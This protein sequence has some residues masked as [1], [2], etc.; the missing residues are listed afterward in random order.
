MHDRAPTRSWLAVAAL[1]TIVTLVAAPVL[2]AQS[3]A[4]VLTPPRPPDTTARAPQVTRPTAPASTANPAAVPPK[5][6][7]VPQSALLDSIREAVFHSLL[8]HDRAGFS[9]LASA[10]CLGL[11]T[12]TFK[13]ASNLADRAD[14]PEAMVRRLYTPRAPARRA[15]TCTFAP[16]AAARPVPGRALLYSVGVIDMVSPEHAEAAAAYSYDGYSA[17]GYTFTVERADS[18]WVVKQ[19]RMEWTAKSGAP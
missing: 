11:S 16:N 18:G 12:D 4:K 15:S 7:A 13:K 2:L 1:V 6:V 19:W 9:T 14:P 8:D 5:A 3:G 10:F 17:G